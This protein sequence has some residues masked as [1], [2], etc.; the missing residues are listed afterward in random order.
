MA[1]RT[2]WK[3]ITGSGRSSSI[4]F[5]NSY[6]AAAEYT[7]RVWHSPAS[8]LRQPLFLLSFHAS[9]GQPRRQMLF[10]DDRYGRE[11]GGRE[12]ILPLD[13]VEA[14]EDVDA[15]GDGLQ[16][17]SGHERQGDRV[18]IP[19]IDEHEDQRGD[20]AGCG[21]RQEHPDQG[22]DRSAAVDLGGLLHL[23]G[24][25]QK[26][27]AQQ[28]DRERLVECG[29]Q[30]DQ[31]EQAVH[32]A[33]VRHQLVDA[34]EQHDRCEHLAHDDEPEKNGLAPELHAAHRVGRRD[35]AEDRDECRSACHDHRV[36]KVPEN[37]GRRPDFDEIRPFPLDRK[38]RHVER[39]HFIAV[40]RGGREHDEIRVEDDDAQNDHEQIDKNFLPDFFSFPCH[41]SSFSARR[42]RII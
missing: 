42:D 34:D 39:I 24:D 36:H 32:E 4:A 35:A 40:L 5:E 17:V 7:G 37:R 19:G 38:D 27:S 26:R 31:A 29:V 22:A 14:V 9:C 11:Q 1:K 2:G 18:F 13:H 8:I 20:D 16:R 30:K 6:E 28:P 10:D 33:E 23:G 41:C 15:D 3:Y 25:G 21:H 12:Q